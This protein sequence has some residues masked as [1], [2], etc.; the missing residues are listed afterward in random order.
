MYNRGK[1]LRERYANFLP[2]KYS[3]TNVYIQ[4]SD[5][6]RVLISAQLLL[7]GLF[8]PKGTDVW[9]DK[10]MWQP[11]PIHTVPDY[12]DT[13]V[14][15]KVFCSK[16]SKIMAKQLQKED[17]DFEDVKYLANYTGRALKHTF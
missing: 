14:A 1:W 5:S 17:T 11:I 6:D 7:A 2:D 10:L 13:E 15:Q 3:K 8:P 12:N 16:F 9:S 4:A